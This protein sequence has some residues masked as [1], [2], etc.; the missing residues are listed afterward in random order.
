[1]KKLYNANL[2]K[3]KSWTYEVTNATIL[4]N[5]EFPIHLPIEIQ[6]KISAS[7]KKNKRFFLNEDGWIYESD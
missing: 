1:M 2:N 4:I 6:K 7:R 3:I 5:N